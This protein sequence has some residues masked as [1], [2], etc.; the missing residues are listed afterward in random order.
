MVPD[1]VCEILSRSTRRHDVQ[2]KV[3]M[4]LC[5]GVG[6]LWLVDPEARSLQVFRRVPDGWLLALF[7]D[8]DGLVRAEP[9]DAI[10]LDLGPLWSW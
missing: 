9:F 2:V 8:G 7:T 1:W 3:P 6:H 10:E 4:Y 5:H